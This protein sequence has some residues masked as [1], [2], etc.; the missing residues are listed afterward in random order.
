MFDPTGHPAE[1][2][3]KVIVA[4]LPR[5]GTVSMKTALEQLGYGPCHHLMEPA[6]PITRLRKS[7]AILEMPSGFKR[8]QAL[9]SL[10]EGYQV[11]LDVPGSAC[12]DDLLA[13]YPDAKVILTTRKTAQSWLD[14]YVSIFGPMTAIP[15]RA[16]NFWAP[17]VYNAARVFLAWNRVYEERFPGVQVPSVDVYER[18]AAHIRAITPP[19]NLL[20]IPVGSGWGPLCEFL[21]RPVFKG[22]FPRRNERTY[23]LNI[24]RA[25]YA[26]GI[27][28]WGFILAWGPGL[29]ASVLQNE[30]LAVACV[31][32]AML[33]MAMLFSHNKHATTTTVRMSVLIAVAILLYRSFVNETI[34]SLTGNGVTN[35]VVFSC[36]CVQLLRAVD[37]LLLD[38]RPDSPSDIIDA[39]NT[40]WNMREV[41]TYRQ[42]S[43]LPEDSKVPKPGCGP[44]RPRFF[45]RSGSVIMV[46]YLVLEA[47]TAIVPAAADCIQVPNTL[48]GNATARVAGVAGFWLV[49]SLYLSLI[50]NILATSQ[51][52]LFMSEPVDW[53]PLYGAVREA[54]SIRR[55]WG[56]LWHQTLRKTFGSYARRLLKYSGVSPDG[57]VGRYATKVVEFAMS[58]TLHWMAD[59][60]LRVPWAES[61]AMPFFLSHALG[62]LLED[63]ITT[64]NRRFALV[65]CPTV[66]RVIGYVWV[67]AFLIISTP[68]WME[69]T[70]QYVRP[71]VDVMIPFRV[72]PL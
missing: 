6:C 63:C 24:N 27:P 61:G 29:T 42:I 28:L 32:Q 54:W 55:F 60:I 59:C 72:L 37:I 31:I 35:S 50:Y 57:F 62:V 4:G 47:I 51:V 18:H 17:G 26:C 3:L 68:L 8:Q 34:F 48:L 23:L 58:G 21:G 41:G 10:L 71:G 65:Q 16:I 36:L 43:H 14:S 1:T 9:Q 30:F 44:Q 11:S 45:L 13:L 20:E 56:I 67:I 40:L 12:V 39:F 64:A 66:R 69:P 38:P 19:E 53:P 33:S 22:P 7:A 70:S 46:S 49:V 5:T 52:L 2:G 15:Y 25:T